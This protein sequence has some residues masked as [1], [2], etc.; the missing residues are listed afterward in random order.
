MDW[1]AGVGFG[2]KGK[3]MSS[4]SKYPF[5]ALFAFALTA[6][7]IAGACGP[8]IP[9]PGGYADNPCRF[10]PRCGSGDIGAYCDG[11]RDCASGFCCDD[12]NCDGGMCSLSCGGDR[13]CPQDML[14]EHGACFFVCDRD[15][16]CAA[17]QSCE[18][19]N[20]ICE[21]D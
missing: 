13:D 16:D 20:T 10:D 11:D 8:A 9:G 15:R 7:V 4:K 2:L 18:H 14:C 19:G 5:R 12:K 17:G 3:P 21:W 1:N 6:G